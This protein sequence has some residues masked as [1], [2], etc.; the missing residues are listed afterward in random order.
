MGYLPNVE[1]I[2][3]IWTA[4][5][6]LVFSLLSIMCSALALYVYKK[7]RFLKLNIGKMVFRIMIND[8]LINIT[9]ILSLFYFERTILLEF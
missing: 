1:T 2:G 3:N 6:P 4:Y 7:F 8:I 9:S 5:V